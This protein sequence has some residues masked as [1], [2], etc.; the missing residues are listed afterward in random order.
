M[1]SQCIYICLSVLY[2]YLWDALVRIGNNGVTLRINWIWPV[3]RKTFQ[4][5]ELEKLSFFFFCCFFE[6]VRTLLGKYA[7]FCEIKNSVKTFLFILPL[8][9]S[10]T[11]TTLQPKTFCYELFFYSPFTIWNSWIFISDPSNFN[12]EKLCNVRSLDLST[13]VSSS[14]GLN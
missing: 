3:C 2:K 7:N 11:K 8:D 12:P 4:E 9:F 10:V 13:Y 1:F 6:R 5:F 14:F